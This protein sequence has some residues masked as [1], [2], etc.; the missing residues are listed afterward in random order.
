MHA[1]ATLDNLQIQVDSLKSVLTSVETFMSDYVSG[2]QLSAEFYRSVMHSD[3]N[4]SIKL[5]K[6][7]KVN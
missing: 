2:N 4:Q 1:K 6:H 7:S 5:F 3:V